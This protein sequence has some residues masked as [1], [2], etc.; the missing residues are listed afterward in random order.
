MPASFWSTNAPQNGASVPCRSRTLRSSAPSVASS[1]LRASPEGGDRSKPLGETCF[2]ADVRLIASRDLRDLR[3]RDGADVG[4]VRVPCRVVVV[5]GL[6]LVEALE[7][8]ERGRDRR[9][10]QPGRVDLADVGLRDAA[11]RLVGVEDGRTVL[12]PDVGTLAVTLRRIV[13]DREE[14]L[15]DLAEPDPGRIEASPG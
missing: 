10:E 2:G 5:I 4:L 12:A 9:I 14:H 8:L 15:E 13:R 11:L 1:R 7:R 6:G 3:R